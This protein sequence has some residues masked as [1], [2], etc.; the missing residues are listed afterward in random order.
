M[1]IEDKDVT[2]NTSAVDKV[3]SPPFPISVR[4]VVPSAS[5]AI[6]PLS[7][8]EDCLLDEFQEPGVEEVSDE[9]MPEFPEYEYGEWDE[10][11]TH[12]FGPSFN[13][14]SE[15]FQVL[16]LKNFKVTQTLGP[17]TKST[18]EMLAVLTTKANEWSRRN[19]KN[20]K[21]EA[22][23]Q[24]MEDLVPIIPRC[25]ITDDGVSDG[26][27]LCISCLNIYETETKFTK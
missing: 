8:Q 12:I 24:D 11:W 9:D 4:D 2:P 19:F 1:D 23:V 17:V 18:Q 22:W 27:A 7:D 16:S 25:C 26:K 10:Q 20:E 21:I 5:P 15:S 14:F 6:E 3:T 13:P